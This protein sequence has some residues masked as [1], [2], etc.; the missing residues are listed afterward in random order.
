MKKKDWSIL[1]SVT[2][3]F[4]FDI[5]DVETEAEAIYLAKERI[6]DKFKITRGGIIDR[7]SAEY[8]DVVDYEE[9]L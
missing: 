9:S 2:I 1:G 7:V 5:L 4:S 8:L 3:D 6:K